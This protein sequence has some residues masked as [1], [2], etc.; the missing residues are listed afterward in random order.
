LP[1]QQVGSA[2]AVEEQV[3]VAL[4]GWAASAEAAVVMVSV[5]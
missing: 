4:Q 2:E 1:A 5:G 3:E